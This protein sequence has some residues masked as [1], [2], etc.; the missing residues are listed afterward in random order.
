MIDPSGG[1]SFC[2]CGERLF[3]PNSSCL[4]CGAACGY[5]PA[6]GK[7][8]SIGQGAKQS[9][10]ASEWRRCQNYEAHAGCNWLVHES[11]HHS[12]CRACRLNRVIPNL[13]SEIN[14]KR[15]RE[16]ESAKRLVVAQL[17]RLGLP[18]ASKVSEDLSC[19][20]LF[21]FLDP[22][23]ADTPVITSHAE[24]VITLNIAEADDDHRERVRNQLNE[25][26]RTL[27]GHFRHELGHHYWDRL[28]ANT[29]LL[30]EFR[31]VFG[32]ESTDY[33]AA[34]SAHYEGDAS[35]EV[36]QEH[37]SFYAGSHPWE[38]WAE[39]W[40]HYLML[41]EARNVAHSYGIVSSQLA[42][43]K[44]WLQA[45]DLTDGDSTDSAEFVT[46]LNEWT[47]L[48][49]VLNEMARALGHRDFY[50]FALTQAVARKLYFIHRVIRQCSKK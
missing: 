28:I 15:W 46:W 36:P 45:D 3:F 49:V 31:R 1:A 19:G 8:I 24:G 37:V 34:L 42:S 41:D 9:P 35:P 6:S 44:Q 29:P 32:D 47:S 16:I 50:P 2:V 33:A 18:V 39:T 27:A 38:D 11:D 30:M 7:V 17:I 5:E 12:F 10:T 23:L 25:P 43:Y 13:E 40:T 26:V 4:S 21:D 20:L 48:A 22:E 14:Q